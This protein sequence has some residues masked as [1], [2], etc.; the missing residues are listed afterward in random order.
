MG[1][2]AQNDELI[3]CTVHHANFEHYC[4]TCDD[5][6]C[7]HCLPDH[8]EH[9][10]VALTEQFKHFY[11]N[12]FHELVMQVES[13]VS[14]SVIILKHSYSLVLLLLIFTV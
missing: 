10:T 14:L 5:L 13:K 4:T 11:Q 8:V 2:P 3:L 12:Q 7:S 9:T 1:D 6:L